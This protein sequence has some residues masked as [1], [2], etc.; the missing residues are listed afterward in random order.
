MCALNNM[1]LTSLEDE[2]EDALKI[3]KS[4]LSLEIHIYTENEETQ[5]LNT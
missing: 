5:K 3:F 1:A 4:N 2:I